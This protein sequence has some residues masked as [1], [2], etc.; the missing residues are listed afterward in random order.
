MFLSRIW[1]SATGVE[2]KEL[3]GHSNEVSSIDI[4]KDGK[5]IL[6]GSRDFTIR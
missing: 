3:K 5:T 6:S 2:T 1:D 4:T